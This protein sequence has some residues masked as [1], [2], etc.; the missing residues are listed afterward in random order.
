MEDVMTRFKNP[1]VLL[2]VLALVAIAV[3][4]NAEVPQ[5]INYQGRLTD[6]TGVPVTD[7]DYSI[8][9]IIYDAA[10]D[11]DILWSSDRMV[12][13]VENGLFSVELGPMD[14]EIFASAG[15]RYLGIRVDSDPEID[16]RTRLISV[17]YALSSQF[18]GGW[19]DDG[20]TVRLITSSDNVGIGVTSP[21][22]KLEVLAS[23]T[24]GVAYFQGAGQ[25][26]VQSYLNVQPGIPSAYAFSG[27]ASGGDG[28][29][30]GVY[31][32]ASEGYNGTGV[33][34]YAWGNTHNSIGVIGHSD[35]GGGAAEYHYGIYGLAES[36]QLENYGLYAQ[37]SGATPVNYGV[38]A[39][40]WG[41]TDNYA[42]YFDGNVECTD[43]VQTAG[44]KMPTG[45]GDGYVLTSDGEGNGTWQATVS[46]Y[47]EAG[48]FDGVVNTDMVE[49]TAVTT[50]NF[51]SPFTSTEKPH[52]YITVVLKAAADGLW[53]GAAIKAV[54]DIKGSAGNWSGFDITVSKYSGGSITDT[55]PVYVTWMAISR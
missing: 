2:A 46:G 10:V 6:D 7:G 50:I 1:Q 30:Q 13:P 32:L 26:G 9:F 42:G 47:G 44:Y 14:P 29:N 17:P 31:G 21:T 35:E 53:E 23:G 15:D 4:V 18:G 39:K 33:Y 24:D 3:S 49:Y 12:V 55:S 34:G 20:T 28:H 38:Y 22:N 45:A 19:A 37:A 5:L 51:D 52:M 54:E 27:R 43:T 40:A 16:P 11:G 41:G 48:E 36:A 25:H 8:F